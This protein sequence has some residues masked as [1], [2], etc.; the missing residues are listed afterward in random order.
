[1]NIHKK[2]FNN[3]ASTGS[4]QKNCH[5][6]TKEKRYFAK[7][8]LQSELMAVKQIGRL[9]EEYF[10]GMQAEALHIFSSE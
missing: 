5:S 9:I 8:V 2:K 6:N 7:S 10:A 4:K 1:M 3:H